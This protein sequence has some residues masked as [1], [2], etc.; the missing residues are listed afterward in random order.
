[1]G[2]K[3]IKSKFIQSSVLYQGKDFKVFSSLEA[4]NQADYQSAASQDPIERIRETVQLI[5][6]VYPIN[7]RKKSTNRIYFN[8]C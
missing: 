2:I 1:M 8:K 3:N 7:E 4:A 5:L 6:R